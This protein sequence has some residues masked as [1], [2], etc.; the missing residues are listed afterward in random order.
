M[1]DPDAPAPI[2]RFLFWSGNHD[3]V[4][5]LR[6]EEAWRAMD[7]GGLGIVA[8][9]VANRWDLSVNYDLVFAMAPQGP[10]HDFLMTWPG[11]LIVDIYFDLDNPEVRADRDQLEAIIRRA[12]CVTAGPCADAYQL[13][14]INPRTVLLPD[15]DPDDDD[16]M[17]A[18]LKA[19]M[20]AIATAA[21]TDRAAA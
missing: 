19:A 6:G 15:L 3:W 8:V 21:R 12:E 1:T 13:S 11:K 4:N 2:R 16:S 17:E 9:D 20:L 18:Y 10:S 14:D 7:E 5:R